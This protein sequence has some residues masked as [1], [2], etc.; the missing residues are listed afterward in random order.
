MNS[1]GNKFKVE[2]F[3]ESHGQCVGVTLDGVPAGIA[4]S[5]EDFSVDVDRR[6]PSSK[7]TTSRKESDIP[8][9]LSG[10]YDDHTN[11]NPLT[12]IFKNENTRSQDYKNLSKHYRPSHIDFVASCKYGQFADLR[13]GGAFSGRLTLPL[14]AAGVVAKKILQKQLER[15]LEFNSNIISVGG[16][17]FGQH[18]QLLGDAMKNGDSL[19]GIIECSVNGLPVGL[20]EPFFDSIESVLSHLLF[21]IPAVKGVEFGAGF[22]AASM[23]GSEHNDPIISH[24]GKTKTNNAGGV[25]GGITNGNLLVFRVVVKPTASISREQMTWNDDTGKVESLRVKGRHDSCIALRAPVVVESAAA[26]GLAQFVL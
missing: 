1:F 18:E 2:I 12:I 10:V 26:I 24:D 7:G 22:H 4:M 23:K 19:G 21:A 15:T 9:F 16:V 5:V 11:G 3:G 25:V 6:R 17:P 14:V 8:V 13:G 20:G